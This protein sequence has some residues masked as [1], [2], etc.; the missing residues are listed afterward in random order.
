[1]TPAEAAAFCAGAYIVP[2][3]WTALMSYAWIMIM[4]PAEAA[5]PE[6]FIEATLCG[7]FWPLLPVMR[8]PK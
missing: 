8:E 2:A 1:M 7:L 4:D 3:I 6:A 5:Q